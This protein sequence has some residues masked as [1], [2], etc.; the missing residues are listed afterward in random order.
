MKRDRFRSHLTVSHVHFI[1][2]QHNRN[3]FAHARDVSV[4]RRH[5]LIRRSRRHVEHDNRALAVN[6]IS[7]SQPAEFLLTGSIPAIES[8]RPAVG[9]KIERVHRHANRG[10]VFLLK[11]TSQ[12]TLDER[13][14]TCFIL[15]FYRRTTHRKAAEKKERVSE[16]FIEELL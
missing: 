2:A 15:L 10:E 12:V 6:V 1:P 11:L 5:V 13:R 3:V 9:V 4:P 7:I 16:S 14:F 8:N